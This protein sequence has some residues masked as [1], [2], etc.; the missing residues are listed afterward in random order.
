M[1]AAILV[2]ESYE[3]GRTKLK[4]QQPKQAR[5]SCCCLLPYARAC[6]DQCEMYLSLYI[7]ISF[8]S[9]GFLVN[10]TTVRSLPLKYASLFNRRSRVMA[11]A[12]FDHIPSWCIGKTYNALCSSLLYKTT[13]RNHYQSKFKNTT[14]AKKSK[15]SNNNY[16]ECS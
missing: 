11:H 9:H 7:Y 14:R 15:S 1:F 6:K 2:R 12:L 13:S 10:N 3:L 16:I 4:A 5:T 8:A